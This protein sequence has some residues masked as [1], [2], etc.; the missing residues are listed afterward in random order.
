[1]YCKN[2]GKQIPDD[3]LFCQ[4]CGTKVTQMEEQ[5]KQPVQE[6]VSF[7]DENIQF[8]YEDT[9]STN[10]N[11]LADKGI[12]II[13]LILACMLALGLATNG[14]ALFKNKDKKEDKVEEV[15]KEETEEKEEKKEEKK[16]EVEAVVIEEVQTEPVQE[17]VPDYIIP[18][19]SNR[20]ISES[21]LYGLSADECCFARNEIYARHHRLFNTDYIQAYFYTKSWYDGYIA[22]EAFTADL[23]NEYEAVN[24]V[25]I[26]NY[27]KAMGWQ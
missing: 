21:E 27:E 15:I 4:F 10:K 6:T 19:S 13:A 2:C 16:E 20:Y 1:M 24:V 17:V 5:I 25:T 26:L 3:S 22:P 23:L 18:D 11:I 12:R 14:I 9:P 7:E 8:E